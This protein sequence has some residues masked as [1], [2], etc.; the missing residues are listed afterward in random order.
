MA[1]KEKLMTWG[2]MLVFLKEDKQITGFTDAVNGLAS[3][4]IPETLTIGNIDNDTITAVF[5]EKVESQMDNLK[6]MRFNRRKQLVEDWNK[7]N[8]KV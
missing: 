2:D 5:S 1:K 8:R 6:L 7:L 3:S 4:N